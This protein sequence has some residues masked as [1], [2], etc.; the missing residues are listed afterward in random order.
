MVSELSWLRENRPR[1]MEEFWGS[2]YPSM[3]GIGDNIK[4][5]EKSGYLPTGHF[6]IPEKGWWQDYYNP[7]MKRINEL[8]KKY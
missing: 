5:I 6:I 4:I 3:K 8:R 1:E 2:N 7:L